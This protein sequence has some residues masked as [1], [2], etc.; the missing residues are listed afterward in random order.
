VAALPMSICPQAIS[1]LRP[2][3][4]VDLVRPVMPCLVAV[5]G[6]ELG[7]G[8]IAEIDPLL[9]MRPPRG[10][11][12]FITR[13]ACWVQRKGPV[14]FVSTTLRHSSNVSSSRGRPGAD[15]PALLKSTST[16]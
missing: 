10:D 1:Y 2:S 5:Y 6:A 11:C 9:M 15:T 3:S 13:N 16:R 7:L 4:D 14:R 12:S 8:D